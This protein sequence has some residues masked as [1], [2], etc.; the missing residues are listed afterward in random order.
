MCPPFYLLRSI[1]LLTKILTA[2]VITGELKTKDKSCKMG[3]MGSF[4][5]SK[6]ILPQGVNNKQIRPCNNAKLLC[7]KLRPKKNPLK[8]GVETGE[9]AGR[10]N[11]W[12]RG[13]L[14]IKQ[15]RG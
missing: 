12:R 6:E 4:I 1:S 10:S 8:N 3:E 14:K 7:L 11:G 9:N 5:S 13:E 15:F 2:T